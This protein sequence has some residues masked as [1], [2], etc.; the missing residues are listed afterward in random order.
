MIRGPQYKIARRLG[1]HL[2]EK[3]Q[4]QKFA[5]RAQRKGRATQ[6]KHPSSRTDFGMQLLEKQK[7]RVAYG[8]SER[9]FSRYVKDAVA[10]KNANSIEKLNEGL[11]PRLDNVVYRS[12]FA[13]TRAGGRQMVS[14]GHF[15]VN[16]KR[17]TIPSYT[18]KK[19][20]IISIREGS[21]NAGIFN[22]LIERITER[23]SPEWLTVDSAL[24]QVTISA[25]PS[26]GG[27]DI[28]FNLA[29][30]VEFYSR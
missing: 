10:K 13:P 16:G 17:V 26:A 18:V 22:S 20:D 25:M 3:T 29:A 9:Q 19:G 11:E 12:G 7:L 6:S 15:L 23:K 27:I 1:A 2:F 8:I 14:H 21:K 4:T 5:A 28:N 30:V 24:R